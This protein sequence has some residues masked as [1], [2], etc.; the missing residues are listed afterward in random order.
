MAAVYAA[1]HRNGAQAA[2]KILHAHYARRAD[3]R[4]RFLRE[5]YIANKVGKGAVGVIDDDVDDDGSPYLVMDLLHGEPIDMRLQRL[6]GKLPLAEVLW[7]ATQTLLTLERAHEHGIIHRDLKPDN[8]FWTADQELKVLDFGVARLRD[9]N[10]TE[11]TR[12]GTVVGTPT[13]MAPEQAI[14]STSEID[15]RSDIWSLGAIMFR[16]LTGRHV[17][18]GNQASALVAAATKR[19]PPILNVDTAI[20]P[21]VAKIVDTALQF[22]REGR[23]PT[24]RAMREAIEKVEGT[25]VATKKARFTV[26]RVSRLMRAAQMAEIEAA[27]GP[28]K[29]LPPRVVDP[30]AASAPAAAPSAP[31]AAP[32]APAAAP[33]APAST[34]AAEDADRGLATGMSDDDSVALHA[35]LGLIEEAVLARAEHGPAHP[36]TIRKVDGAFRRASAALADAHIGL[37]W[38]VV[39]EGFVARGQL[40]WMA[41]P[42][43]P[44]TPARMYEG[45]VRM[46]GLLPGLTKAELEEVVRLMGGDLAPFS[47]FATFLHEGQHPHL[48]HR[49]DPTPPGAKEHES[50]SVEPSSGKGVAAML[51]ALRASDGGAL[52]VT[53][54]SRLERWGEGYES[55]IG[56]ALETTGVELAM[57]LLR[58]L[59]VIDNAAARGAIERAAKSPHPI[60][61]IV[62]L[63]YLEAGDKLRSELRAAL[64]A[65]DP[66]ARLELLVGIEK[67][68]VMSAGPV[69]A[70]RIRAPTFDAL[71]VDER[72]QALST[73]GTL[74]PSRAEAIA[75]EL[76]GDQRLLENEDHEASREAA[77]QLLGTLG[78]SREARDALETA[79][80]KRWRGSD[81]I[82]TAATVALASFDARAKALA[83]R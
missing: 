58:V 3:A 44:P 48:V 76:L 30:A 54:L 43:L 78:E 61:R 56:E 2:I 82:R 55:E 31:A 10:T 72:R 16:A 13:F 27:A 29:A 35:L 9:A 1:S 66:A 71:P 7:I 42:P 12:T 36:K 41:K 5:A 34:G 73:L 51:G 63:T 45:G 18:V 50:V 23:F 77:A 28:T 40:V 39:P 83:A 37:F 33:S 32:S 53:L 14:G 8:L 25:V 68:K 75:I 59:H 47:D 49:I 79:T 19:A 62:A 57:G 70:L 74:M 65:P 22:E 64:E 60:V 6:G 26:P 52:R 21:D 81:R 67:Y 46:L 69:L 80:K 11:T 15:A 17:H 24:A 20:P 4:T 38:N